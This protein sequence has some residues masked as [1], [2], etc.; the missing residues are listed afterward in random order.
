MMQY[1][2]TLI[3]NLI[4]DKTMDR[5]LSILEQEG[6]FVFPKSENL[7][8]DQNYLGAGLCLYIASDDQVDALGGIIEEILIR[9]SV[10]YFSIC[11]V[12]TIHNKVSWTYSNIRVLS[13]PHKKKQI[14][15][16]PYLRLVQKSEIPPE[17]IA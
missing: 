12:D 13:K 4:T 8:F 17:E 16:V 10:K 11:V 2:Y 3:I 14:K 1:S 9:Y 15:K 6:I 5:T 7:I